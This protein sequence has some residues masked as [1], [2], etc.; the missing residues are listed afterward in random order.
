[1]KLVFSKYESFQIHSFI[2]LYH[3][4]ELLRFVGQSH[5][6]I[7]LIVENSFNFLLDFKIF[8]SYNLSKLV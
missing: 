4:P 8:M 1:V 2:A 7:E 3:N 5:L 6:P